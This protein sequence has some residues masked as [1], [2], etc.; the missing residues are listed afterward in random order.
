M[1]GLKHCA[2]DRR[3]RAKVAEEK[4]TAA[5]KRASSAPKNR[6][7]PAEKATPANLLP[8]GLLLSLASVSE[9]KKLILCMCAP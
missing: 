6:P 4:A 2:G 3:K 5:K 8:P 7:K 9:R 1:K